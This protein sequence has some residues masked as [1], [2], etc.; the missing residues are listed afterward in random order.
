[1]LEHQGTAFGQKH[2]AASGD[3]SLAIL[4]PAELSRLDAVSQ[5]LRQRGAVVACDN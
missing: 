5:A 4:P 3:T 2:H 1:M